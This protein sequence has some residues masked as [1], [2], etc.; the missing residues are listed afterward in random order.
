MDAYLSKP[1]TASDLDM[2]LTKYQ[3]TETI[4][5]DTTIESEIEIL[6]RTTWVTEGTRHLNT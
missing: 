2:I 4:S 1:V 6:T 3:M 5:T